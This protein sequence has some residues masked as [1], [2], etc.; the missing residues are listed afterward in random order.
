MFVGGSVV[1][2]GTN[3][4]EVSVE[5]TILKVEPFPVLS[6]DINNRL[7]AEED[8]LDILIS[9]RRVYESVIAVPKGAPGWPFH[10]WT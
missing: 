9:Q 8:E 2:H 3:V 10:R 4:D 6:Y 5:R 1:K 7:F